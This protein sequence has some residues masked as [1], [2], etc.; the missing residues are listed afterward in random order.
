V[1]KWM[2]YADCMFKAQNSLQICDCAKIVSSASSDN[3]T[4]E[5]NFLKDVHLKTDWTLINVAFA[6][7]DFTIEPKNISYGLYAVYIPS[8]P[9]HS[10]FHPPS[11][12]G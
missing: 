5:S 3:P 8:T 2:A 11:V 4:K 1:A 12:N 10:L 9:Q 6:D 7:P